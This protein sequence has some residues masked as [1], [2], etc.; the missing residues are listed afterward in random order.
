MPLY[1]RPGSP[2]WWVRIGRKTRQS[3]GTQDREKAKEF[4]RVLEERLWRRNK[5]GDR[6]AVPWREV[7][8]RWLTDSKRGRKRD[9]EIL[10]W[11][12]PL[13][14]NEMV[15]SVAD[16]DALEMLRKHG[17][18]EGWSHSTVD[19]MMRT[20][21]SVLKRCVVWRLLEIAPHVPMYGEREPEPRFLTPDQ[22]QRLVRELPPHLKVAARFAVLTLLRMRSQGQLT[23]DRIDLRAAR[24]W[25]PGAQMKMHRTHGFP[26]SKDAVKV[27]RETRLL[28]PRGER[29]FQY[30]GAPID[31]FNTQAFKKAAG[32]AGV[33]PLRWH[34]LRHT[35]ASWAVQSGVTLQELQVLGDWKSYRSVL[36]YAFLAPENAVSAAEKVAQMS[37]TAKRRPMRKVL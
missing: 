11:L 15:A 29:V 21:R 14:G 13:I 17:L 27:L 22:F 10:A 4:E 34:D 35:G 16:P 3:T 5:L 6:A 1:K 25:I 7:A 36:K 20:V 2:F 9:R 19:R 32:R 18:K 23:W 12:D 31:N 26:L 24:A 8:D 37:H 28:S 33:L 30:E